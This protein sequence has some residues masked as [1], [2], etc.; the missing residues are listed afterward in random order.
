MCANI[1]QE[2]GSPYFL[3]EEMDLTVERQESVQHGT[4]SERKGEVPFVIKGS[5]SCYFH[6][7]ICHDS[8]AEFI[9]NK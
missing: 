7:L 4:S 5:V 3:R 1:F 9:S 8:F 2:I 6:D